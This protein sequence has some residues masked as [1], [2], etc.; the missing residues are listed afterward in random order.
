MSKKSS[1]L[2]PKPEQ[3]AVNYFV[4]W[5]KRIAYGLPGNCDWCGDDWDMAQAWSKKT[6]NPIW[7]HDLWRGYYV[8][9]SDDDQHKHVSI[10]YRELWSCY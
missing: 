8:V 3:G 4:Q 10:E 1:G 6:G 5:A 2:P 7:E 9:R